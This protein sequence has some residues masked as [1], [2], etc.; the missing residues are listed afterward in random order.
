MNDS[1]VEGLPETLVPRS[2]FDPFA[3]EK[4]M[5][6]MEKRESDLAVLGIKVFRCSATEVEEFLDCRREWNWSSFSR[7]GL[8]P[9]KAHS[10]LTFG[11]VI[12]YALEQ[13]Y[14]GRMH[15]P[16][17]WV[18]I[19]AEFSVQWMIN[20]MQVIYSQKN[21]DMPD[22]TDIPIEEAFENALSL[23]YPEEQQEYRE[24]ETLGMAMLQNYD[25][26]S[27]K[28]DYSELNGFQ[29]VLYTEKEF[30][31]VIPNV[32]GTPYRFTDANGQIW[33]MW[34]VGRLDMIVE[35]YF[36]RIWALDHKTSKDRLTEEILILDDQMTK[37]LWAVTQ[38]LKMEPEGIFYN[39]LR[40]KLPRVPKVLVSGKSLT[41]DKS[42]DT[43]YEVYYE[44]ILANGFDPKD[45]TEILQMLQDKK[46]GFFERARVRRN[47]YEIRNAGYQLLL[48][49]ID[50]LNA[51]LI[52]PHFTWDCRWKCDFREL[53]A[54]TNRNDDTEWLKNSCFKKR[55]VVDTSVY[56]RE[57]TI[58]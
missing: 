43:T 30:A 16:S 32:D 53:C 15:Q 44:A 8:E 25:V 38:I 31:V 14:K 19:A 7:E 2:T 13:Y 3:F 54:A 11:T 4:H 39:V 35:D 55:V 20:T 36:G 40:K 45:Y 51:P 37:Y 49:A 48:Q 9:K 17:Y 41:K 26:W 22:W 12:H 50:M 1:I 10:A 46:D 33:E 6:M 58:K 27:Q 23:L 47:T 18:D 24:L 56:S 57:S 52:Y 21:L 5:M 42:I 28:E 29:R 34:L